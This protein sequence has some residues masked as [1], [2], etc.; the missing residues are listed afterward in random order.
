MFENHKRNGKGTSFKEDGKI[1][2]QGEWESGKF[3]K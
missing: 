2:K 3:I 1:E